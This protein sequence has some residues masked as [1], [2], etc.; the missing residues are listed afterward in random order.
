MKKKFLFVLLFLIF[1]C[2]AFGFNLSN[3]LSKVEKE[4]F[5]ISS[6]FFR[7]KADKYRV[8]QAKSQYLPH[9]SF[10]AYLG[11]ERYKPYYSDEVQ[12]TLKYY[13]LTLNQPVYHPEIFEKIKQTEIYSE[14]D[15]LKLKQEK[16]YIRYYLLV[17][18]INDAYAERK[19]ELYR[20][21]LYV[22]KVRLAAVK[23]LYSKK[24]LSLDDVLAVQKDIAEVESKVRESELESKVA[25]DTLTLILKGWNETIYLNSRVSL[26][27]LL[28]VART[29]K[30]NL[31]NNCE[32]Q[33][34][35][36]NLKVAEKEMDIRKKERY[37]KVDLSLSY[38]Y[39]TTS[40]ISVASR[41]K[42]AFLTFSVPIFQGGYLFSRISEAK[43]LEKSALFDLKS[44]EREKEIQFKN[45]LNRLETAASS[46]KYLIEQLK[47]DVAILKVVKKQADLG[48][49]NRIDVLE[50]KKKIIEDEISLTE[51]VKRGL[52]G[53]VELLYLTT[54]V[55]SK[56]LN[57][58]TPF[59]SQR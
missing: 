15:R 52:T 1:N 11:W 13:Y 34:A 32:I 40:A 38:S 48:L 47:N 4:D 55:E 21:L 28:N 49:K 35:K 41:D 20:E 8:R 56:Y 30:K 6:L 29:L 42:R 16:Q 44:T 26:E 33:I 18:L 19:K 2:N 5:K 57:L 27:N 54:N 45:S 23:A 12:Q 46:Q 39:T 17:N 53:Y 43:D 25:S 50:Q 37:P 9:V 10:T 24:F 36:L 59:F 22:E 31:N 51:E 7:V 58:F 14:I 3:L